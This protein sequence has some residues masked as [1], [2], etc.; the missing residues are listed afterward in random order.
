MGLGALVLCLVCAV[1]YRNPDKVEIPLAEGKIANDAAPKPSAVSQ[2]ATLFK[3][4]DIWMLFLA[5][6]FLNIVEWGMMTNLVLYLK[7]SLLFGVVAAGGLLAMTEAAGALGK[8]ASGL[9]SDRLLKGQRKVVFML[10]A[11]VAVLISLVLGLVG[12]QIEWLLYPVLLIFGLMAIG[13]GGLYTAL[14]GELAGKDLAGIAAGTGG[15]MLVLGAMT[16]PPLFGFIVDYTGS[17]EVAWLFMALSGALSV[18][19]MSLVRE[20]RKRI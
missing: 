3:S 8:P 9:V 11:S 4:R 7:E 19:F 20:Y 6:F 17:Y 10:M 18:G 15:F 1:F 13:W 2:M 14:V 16:G 5:G 12:H